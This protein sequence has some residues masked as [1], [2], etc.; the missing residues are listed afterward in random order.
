MTKKLTLKKLNE[1]IENIKSALHRKLDKAEWKFHQ[2]MKARIKTIMESTD[3]QTNQP[4]PPWKKRKKPLVKRKNEP[5]W[6][7]LKRAQK[8][9][10]DLRTKLEKEDD[11]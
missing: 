3:N 4:K 11:S 5:D 9:D 10:D 2:D 6:D 1:E 7:A 8:K